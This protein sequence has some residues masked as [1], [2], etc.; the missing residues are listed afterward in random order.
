MPID[1][2]ETL[3]EGRLEVEGHSGLERTK[4]KTCSYP[5]SDKAS[6]YECHGKVNRLPGGSRANPNIDPLCL[7]AYRVSS[8]I[9]ANVIDV[10][11]AKHVPPRSENSCVSMSS[12]DAPCAG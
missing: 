8:R 1:E 2:T 10:R 6:V 4:I 12:H 7:R 5:R 11:N 9:E 3:L